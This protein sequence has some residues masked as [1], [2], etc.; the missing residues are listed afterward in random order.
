MST[1]PVFHSL[2]VCA[3]CGCSGEDFGSVN[4]EAFELTGE[5]YCEECAG[6]VIADFA[7]DDDGCCQACGACPGFIGAECDE[8]CDHA[9]AQPSVHGGE[10]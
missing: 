6:E 9:K 7:D 4:V 10:D 3:G 8:T 1:R 5:L 2:S